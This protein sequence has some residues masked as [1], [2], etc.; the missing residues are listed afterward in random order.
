LSRTYYIPRNIYKNIKLL[1]T[2]ILL[3]LKENRKVGDKH[4]GISML[5]LGGVIIIKTPPSREKEN[6]RFIRPPRVLYISGVL[7]FFTYP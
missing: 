7:I 3:R 6:M 1:H 4:K 5:G 2:K